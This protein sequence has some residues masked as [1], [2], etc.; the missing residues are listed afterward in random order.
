MARVIRQHWRLALLQLLVVV[1]GVGLLVHRVLKSPQ[2]AI[3]AIVDVSGTGGNTSG[4][5][6]PKQSLH[7][8]LNEALHYR[9]VLQLREKLSLRNVDIAAMG[10]TQHQATQMLTGLST[11]IT[12][13]SVKLEQ[14]EQLRIEAMN[15]LAVALT[16][17]NIGPRD[18]SVLNQLPRLQQNV[19]S[20]IQQRDQTLES[21]AAIVT[22]SLSPTQ[23][24]IWAAAKANAALGAPEQFRY[25]QGLTIEQAEALKLA[26][27]RGGGRNAMSYQADQQI[28]TAKQ[29]LKQNMPGVLVAE[30]T[31]LPLPKIRQ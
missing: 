17:V 30:Q 4:T 11:W 8:K 13:N 25:A 14:Q 9:R 23:Q 12:A 5:A 22:T 26:A 19:A 16:Q 28:E 15:A 2:K 21:A 6:Q 24:Q 3:A 7:D 27:Y 1:A 29:N 10:C 18:E 20:A 31:V